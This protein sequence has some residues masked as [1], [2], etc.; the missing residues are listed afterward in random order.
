[1]RNSTIK[2]QRNITITDMTW[3]ALQERAVL[4]ETT[5]SQICEQLLISYLN[6]QLEV[7]EIIERD[8]PRLRTIY[9][10]NVLWAAA[11]KQR[12]LDHRSISKTLEGLLLQFLGEDTAV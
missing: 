5:A 3:A 12:V 2:K 10:T 1:M 11:R 4:E 8:T 9:T 6:N 7:H